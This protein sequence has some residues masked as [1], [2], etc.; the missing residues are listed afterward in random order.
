MDGD[1]LYSIGDLA[2][3]TGLSVK[4]IRFYADT[5]IVPPTVRSPAGHRLYDID[6]AARLD[7]VRT[8]R[9]LGLDLPTIRRV[10]DREATL[11]E[12]AASHAEALAVQIRTLLLRRAVLLA[13]A[14][15]GSTPEEMDL[16]RDLATL[17]ADERLR[18]VGDFLD[19][20]FGELDTDHGFLGARR[21]MTPELP[22]HPAAEQ[23]EAWVRLAELTRDPQFRAV[24]RRLAEHHAAERAASGH[25]EGRRPI[26]ARPGGD[27][28]LGAC[29]ADGRGVGQRA[30]QGGPEGG[31]AI[32]E[33]GV[34]RSG[35]GE[36]AAEA[37]GKPSGAGR[38]VGRSGVGE[39]GVDR[40]GVG[41]RAADAMGEPSGARRG[42]G[43]VPRRDAAATVR[44]L[45]EPALAAGVDPASPEAAPVVAAVT[46]SYA[47]ALDRP[48]DPD[49]RRDLLAW[50]QTVN[51]PRRELY[52]RLLAVVNGWRPPQSL[53]PA[54]DWFIRAVQV[55]PL[56]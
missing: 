34:G 1:T 49:L 14:R 2:R 53:A 35:V 20:A 25:P 12:V 42:G 17:S 47:R 50:A 13:V 51:D 46:A 38:G 52:L 29:A 19:A 8:L 54:F 32:G 3:R 11:T 30:A 45:V 5:G 28:A 16:M 56:S 6:A 40:S 7:L 22:D 44:D 26:D 37:M 27:D 31:D 36:R 15:H 55:R 48:D 23:V 33:R 21:S 18:L 39:R 9:D 41:E 43:G 4:A 24:M 10:V